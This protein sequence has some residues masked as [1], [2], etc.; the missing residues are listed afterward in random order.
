MV[1]SDRKVAFVKKLLTL[2]DTYSKVVV[3]GADHVGSNQLQ[4]I[5]ARLR[6]SGTLLMGKKTIVR[7]ALHANATKYAAFNVLEPHLRGNVGLLFVKNEVE[8]S[9]IR[10]VIEENRVGAPAKAGSV[11][12]VDVT[13]PTG[14]TGLEP[15]KTSFFQAL[16]IPTKIAKGTVE[17]LVPHLLLKAGDKVGNSE[18]SLLQMMGIKPFS[19]GL[20][21]QCVYDNGIVYDAS[22]LDITDAMLEKS[23]KEAVANLTGFS[24]GASFLTDLSVQSV[25]SSGYRDLLAVAMSTEYSFKQAE[26][27]KKSVEVAAAAAPV[28]AA[29]APEK[30]DEEVK[31]DE[32]VKKEDSAKP[33]EEVGEGGDL[34]L[35]LFG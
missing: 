12:P 15:T 33:A 9:E 29:A 18:A 1:I 25:V 5:R 8:M 13:I 24:L 31:K 3:V 21:I 20:S 32:D 6:G 23:M 14:N 4:K 30:K 7:M 19:Y 35:G 2:L 16:N 10:K 22:V 11:S 17:I 26:Q 34:G 28:A 27:Y